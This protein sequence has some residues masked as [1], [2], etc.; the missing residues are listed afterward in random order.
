MFVL[1]N[2]TAYAEEFPACHLG[3]E[4]FV[5]VPA[6][7]KSDLHISS[8]VRLSFGMATWAAIVLH[9]FG[10]ELYVRHSST[11]AEFI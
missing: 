9:T 4:T 5:G 11:R 3:R 10:I 7:L 2:T 8:A 6:D 1:G